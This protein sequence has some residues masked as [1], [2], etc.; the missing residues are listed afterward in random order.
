[1][2]AVIYDSYYKILSGIWVPLAAVLI[3]SIIL[4]IMTNYRMVIPLTQMNAAAKAIANGNFSKRI[5]VN[6]RDEVGQ[7]AK[8]FNKMAEGA[9]FD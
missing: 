3:F 7:L 2:K 6:T 5:Y 4:I 1:M 8:S 9:F